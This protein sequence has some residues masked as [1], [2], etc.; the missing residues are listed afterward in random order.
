VGGWVDFSWQ[1]WLRAPLQQADPS[2]AEDDLLSVQRQYAELKLHPIS[3]VDLIFDLDIEWWSSSLSEYNGTLFRLLCIE[4]L[5][6]HSSAEA[7]NDKFGGNSVQR[8]K[9]SA[10]PPRM[11][12]PR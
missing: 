8:N 4:L 10:A 11:K 9:V 1:L 5:G 12:L 6:G 2:K 7:N 3:T